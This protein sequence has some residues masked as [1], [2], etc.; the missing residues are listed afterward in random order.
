M[1][2]WGLVVHV[3]D[4][5]GRRQHSM[6][7]LW[8]HPSFETRPGTRPCAVSPQDLP[9]SPAHSLHFKLMPLYLVAL[10]E[11]FGFQNS[12]SNCLKLPKHFSGTSQTRLSNFNWEN[13]LCLEVLPVVNHV[14]SDKMSCCQCCHQGQLPSHYSTTHNSGKLP[15]VFSRI[16]FACSLNT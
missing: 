2:T 5:R 3:G 10:F 15:C 9:L 12:N 1:K 4:R 6:S 7:S 11:K 16:V 14:T 8:G 13:F